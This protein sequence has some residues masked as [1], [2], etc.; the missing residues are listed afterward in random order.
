MGDFQKLIEKEGRH[1]PV[2]LLSGPLVRL[3]RISHVFY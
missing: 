1:P 3:P 2:V